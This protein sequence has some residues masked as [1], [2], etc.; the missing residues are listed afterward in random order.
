MCTHAHARACARARLHTHAGRAHTR[1]HPTRVHA[2]DRAPL[3]GLG[4]VELLRGRLA[5]VRCQLCAFQVVEAWRI[6]EH[7]HTCVPSHTHWF[8]S[9]AKSAAPRPPMCSVL[10]RVLKLGGRAP[11][12][13]PHNTLQ[14]AWLLAAAADALPTVK[15]ACQ[16]ALLLTAGYMEQTLRQQWEARTTRGNRMP[17]SKVRLLY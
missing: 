6:N 1:A 11:A 9:A 10:C 16:P 15:H 4:R 5:A 13:T 2:E 7:Q 12:E 8:G 17:I 3:Q 14:Q